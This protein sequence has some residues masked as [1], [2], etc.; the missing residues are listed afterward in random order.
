M[1]DVLKVGP[2]IPISRELLADSAP[3]RDMLD[4]TFR[5]M[6]HP[7]EFPDRNPMPTVVLL[8]RINRAQQRWT[9]LVERL[10]EIRYVAKHGIPE[11][12]DE[13]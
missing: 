7:W 4:R 3:M 11:P 8:P 12:Y 6:T 5:R 2:S 9:A 13:D 1:T 10:R